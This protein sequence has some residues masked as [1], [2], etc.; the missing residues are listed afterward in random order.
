MPWKSVQE[1][2]LV[3]EQH[4]TTHRDNPIFTGRRWSKQIIELVL[5]IHADEWY[6]RYGTFISPENI[7]DENMSHEMRSL[8][9]TIKLFYEK[10]GSL[11]FSKQK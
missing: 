8:F 9:L 4:Y 10:I 2:M 3:M 1:L 7:D 6:L 5:T 11:P